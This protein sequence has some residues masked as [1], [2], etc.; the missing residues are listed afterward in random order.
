MA[1]SLTWLLCWFIALPAAAELTVDPT[2][3]PPG[4]LSEAA[5]AAAEADGVDSSL[6]VLQSIIRPH[7]ARPAALI[8]GQVVT[9]G[10]QVGD[11]VLIRIGESEVVLRG[12]SGPETLRLSPGVDRQMHPVTTRRRSQ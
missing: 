11:R 1:K 6:P 7:G 3:P 2:R 4:F 5:R 8:D 12:E 10:G 9:L